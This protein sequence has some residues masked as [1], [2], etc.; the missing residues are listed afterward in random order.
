[1]I[2][3]LRLLT[4]L[5]TIALLVG[6]GLAA[7]PE[8][9]LGRIKRSNTITLGYRES[10]RPFSFAGDDGKPAGYSVDLCTRVASSVGNEL[11]LPKLQVK[12]V[13]VTVE[14]RMQ[15][16]T[17]GTIGLEGGSTTAPLTRQAP[18]DLIASTFV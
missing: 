3:S 6:P 14:N 15:A 18:V 5:S 9:T 13:K 4:V 2:Q 1:M 17:D 16:V 11:A 8:G 12:W 7:E 10:S